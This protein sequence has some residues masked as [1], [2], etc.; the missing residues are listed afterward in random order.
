ML[1]SCEAQAGLC[2]G[3]I[4]CWRWC[5]V[6]HGRIRWPKEKR[7]KVNDNSL[8]LSMCKWRVPET[9]LHLNSFTETASVTC[10]WARLCWKIGYQLQVKLCFTSSWNQLSRKSTKAVISVLT[11]FDILC[12]ISLWPCS[13]SSYPDNSRCCSQQGWALC[14]ISIQSTCHWSYPLKWNIF[15]YSPDIVRN[16]TYYK[17]GKKEN[18]HIY[19]SFLNCPALFCLY[20]FFPLQRQLYRNRNLPS[21]W[22]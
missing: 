8:C 12:T 20:F 19:C 11:S 9:T 22:G 7:Q 3:F 2:L 13:S 16:S 6:P 15:F 14:T 5:Q 10:C 18:S 21:D 17:T 1:S 4:F